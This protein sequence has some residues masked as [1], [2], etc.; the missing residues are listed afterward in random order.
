[1]IRAGAPP[2]TRRCGIRFYPRRGHEKP[3]G[4]GLGKLRERFNGCLLE[5]GIDNNNVVIVEQ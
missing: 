5:F 4:N 3:R 2:T 1:M